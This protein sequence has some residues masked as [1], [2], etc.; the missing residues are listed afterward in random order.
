VKQADSQGSGDRW[1]SYRKAGI[2]AFSVLLI[3]VLALIALV[4]E[5]SVSVRFDWESGRFKSIS[6]E[7]PAL[8]PVYG[9]V[10][11]AQAKPLIDS[12]I[13]EAGWKSAQGKIPLRVRRFFFVAG[14]ENEGWEIV[15]PFVTPL[16]HAAGGGDVTDLKR[17][18]VEGAN[19]N[20]RDQR[21][22]TALI[23]AAMNGR[24][25]ATE[26][27]LETGADP[28]LKDQAG[29][30]ALLW[31]A[32]RCATDVVPALIAFGAYTDVH[33][34]YGMSAID[35]TPCPKIWQQVVQNAKTARNK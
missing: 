8:G 27:L 34:N 7:F 20:A 19:V 11:T 25:R 12:R 32:Q 31:A 29:R 35:Y 30:T 26:L 15:D 23:Y 24:V 4:P 2:L 10:I 21:G 14:L 6:L 33:D 5:R 22:W 18:M 9:Y 3:I 28:N 17:L 13:R 1:R 16:M